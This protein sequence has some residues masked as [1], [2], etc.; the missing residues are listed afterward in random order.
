MDFDDDFD[1]DWHTL[2]MIGSLSEEL[3]EL[4][5]DRIRAEL[6]TY[7]LDDEEADEELP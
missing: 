1:L 6:E 7:G 5:R 3:S 4:E 2:A